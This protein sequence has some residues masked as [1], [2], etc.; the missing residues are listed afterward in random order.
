VGQFLYALGH[1]YGLGKSLTVGVVSG[2]NRTIPAPMGT[3]IYGAIQVGLGCL[4]LR[5]VVYLATVFVSDRIRVGVYPLVCTPK[6]EGGG[7]LH[8]HSTTALHTL[9]EVC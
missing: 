3:R 5:G 1:P 8:C 6:H 2:L 4:V 9:A 7:C